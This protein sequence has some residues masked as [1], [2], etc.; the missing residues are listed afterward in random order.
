M[1]PARSLLSRRRHWR[2]RLRIRRVVSGRSIYNYFRDYDPAT[3]RYTQSDPI[4]LNGGLNTYAYVSNS[5]VTRFDR[6]G[7]APAAGPADGPAN[8]PGLPWSWPDS[9]FDYDSP[10][11]RDAASALADFVNDVGRTIRNICGLDDIVMAEQE[12][13]S[14]DEEAAI[15]AKNAGKPYDPA[16]YN[17]A[18][19]KQIKNE[20][21]AKERNKRKRGG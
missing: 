6:F 8:A 14:A 2:N 4:G 19:Q 21:Y 13:L 10:A 16:T 20:K 18:R 5:P 9:I 11:N 12:T 17:R 7:L 3:G 15:R 1:L